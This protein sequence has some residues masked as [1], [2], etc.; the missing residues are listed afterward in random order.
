MIKAKDPM[1]EEVANLSTGSAVYYVNAIEW[2]H[3]LTAVLF[4]SGYL[5]R[6]EDS[7]VFHNN[8]GRGIV[9]IEEDGEEVGR[10]LYTY[11]KMPQSGNWEIV[12]YVT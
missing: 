5:P 7:P 12:C 2:W 1:R 10:V 3:E 4:R 8:E 11:Y 6:F 9:V